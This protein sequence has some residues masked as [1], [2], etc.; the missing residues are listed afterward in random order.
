L[1]PIA[2]LAAKT[3]Y[4]MDSGFANVPERLQELVIRI[5]KNKGPLT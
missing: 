4:D 1:R 2:R 5:I 3:L